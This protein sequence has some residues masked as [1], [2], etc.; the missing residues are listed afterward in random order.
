VTT[1]SASRLLV[2][3]RALPDGTYTRT[4]LETRDGALVLCI[5]D[6]IEAEISVE[7]FAAVIRRYGKP[8]ADEVTVTGDRLD[9]PRG[10]SLVL[11]RHLATY[12][13][14]AKDYLVYTCPPDPPIAELATSIAGALTYLVRSRI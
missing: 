2:D 12:D 3:Q 1:P 10:D 8:L 9:L 5:D 14:I 13:I 4:F 7:I 6:E 11:L